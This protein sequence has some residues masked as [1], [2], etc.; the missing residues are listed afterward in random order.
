[1]PM[2]RLFFL[3]LFI[4]MNISCAQN[5]PASSVDFREDP[6][7][8][9]IEVLFDSALF[10]AYIYP[11]NVMKPVLWPVNTTNGTAITRKFPLE[12]AAG[13]RT[14][15]PHHVGI[16][17]NYGDVNGIDYWNNSEAI[18]PEKKSQYGEIRHQEIVSMSASGNQGE[19]V[20]ISEW[21]DTSG[22]VLDEITRFIF[23]NEGETR[24]IDREATLTAHKDILFEDNK[25]G[26]LGIRVVPELEMPSDDEITLTDAHGNPTTVKGQND[27]A[28]GDYFSSEGIRGDDVWGTRGVWMDLSG[29][30]P[31]HRVD[32]RLIHHL[33]C[34]DQHYAGHL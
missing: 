17:F 33:D 23:I 12:K 20:V 27:R 25:E 13:E 6:K 29:H 32:V 34:H 1:M 7:N 15:H 16:W 14:D 10:T 3:L 19:M 11:E 31:G 26:M 18:P 8:N 30:C 21:I 2:Y 5:E 22:T 24:I 9:K 28:T 4:Y